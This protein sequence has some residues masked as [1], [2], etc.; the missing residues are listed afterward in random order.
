MAQ[1]ER[2]HYWIEV[3]AGPL[4]TVLSVLVAAFGVIYTVN[5]NNHTERNRQAAAVAQQQEERAAS[6][7]LAAVQ[8]VM[9][10]RSCALAAARAKELVR[11]FPTRLKS[12]DF[13][14]LTK[15]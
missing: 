12:P 9:A 5:S 6:F 4:A 11:L 15:P 2:R 8:T 14:R 10:Q 7:E 1:P 3:L 13:K